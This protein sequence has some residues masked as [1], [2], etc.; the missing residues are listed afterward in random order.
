MHSLWNTV[1]ENNAK[2]FNQIQIYIYYS[3]NSNA[4]LL[5]LVTEVL[6]RFCSFPLF[7]DYQDAFA[8]N[9]G[10]RYSG[11]CTI[12]IRNYRS[13]Y[14]ADLCHRV[15]VADVDVHHPSVEGRRQPILT[16]RVV[17]DSDIC[18]LKDLTWLETAVGCK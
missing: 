15:V 7:V 18:L 5:W 13:T 3:T 8:N 9:F 2:S 6:F 16:R 11:H 17:Q 10:L 12:K 14:T 1:K 4:S